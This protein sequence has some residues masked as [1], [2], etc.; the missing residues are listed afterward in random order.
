MQAGKKNIFFAAVA[1]AIAS[2]Y[3][4]VYGTLELRGS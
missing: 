2:V 4:H 3:Y 1:D